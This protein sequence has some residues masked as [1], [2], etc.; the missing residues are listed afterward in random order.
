M[1]TLTIIVML[2][3]YLPLCHSTDPICIG[4]ITVASTEVCDDSVV[5]VRLRREGLCCE[6]L[7]TGASERYA[8]TS[9][10]M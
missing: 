3:G 2:V 6:D 7:N 5:L 1:R 9:F 10:V 4:D 8:N